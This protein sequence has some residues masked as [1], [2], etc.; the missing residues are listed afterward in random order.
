MKDTSTYL[1]KSV[2]VTDP[3]SAWNHQEVDVLIRA[4]VV[5]EIDGLDSIGEDRKTA[6]AQNDVKALFSV[7]D[8]E[9]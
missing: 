1:L 7:Q 3:M 4:G 2:R 6:V 9:Y 5:E 8:G